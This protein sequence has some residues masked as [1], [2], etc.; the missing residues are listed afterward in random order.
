MSCKRN[1]PIHVA[2]TNG[3]GVELHVRNIPVARLPEEIHHLLLVPVHD[4]G[5]GLVV[6]KLAAL[7]GHLALGQEGLEVPPLLRRE[8]AVQELLH[9]LVLEAEV[10]LGLALNLADPVRVAEGLLLDLRVEGPA[11]ELPV[12]LRP[13]RPKVEV[14]EVPEPARIC[15]QVGGGHCLRGEAV[16]RRGPPEA[17]ELPRALLVSHRGQLC[18]SSKRCHLCVVY[19]HTVPL[20]LEGA[21]PTAAGVRRGVQRRGV[22]EMASYAPRCRQ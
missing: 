11:P 18:V 5:H 20:H 9:E 8:R 7:P 12:P 2:T 3:A 6:G 1:T 15:V 10:L 16:A 14:A 4:E 21:R 19:V 22:V 13:V 17:A